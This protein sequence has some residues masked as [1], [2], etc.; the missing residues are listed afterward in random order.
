MPV[1]MN[2]LE[3]RSLTSLTQSRRVGRAQP[4]TWRRRSSLHLE[5]RKWQRFAVWEYP[6]SAVSN[7]FVTH[8]DTRGVGRAAC[9]LV[10]TCKSRSS[11]RCS[12]ML[13]LGR[14]CDAG[15]I[16]SSKVCP[17]VDNSVFELTRFAYFWLATSQVSNLVHSTPII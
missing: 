6:T 16:R 3:I 4:N 7:T 11:D 2:A 14:C 13:S 1:L 15:D 17:L 9:S 5:D 10:K 8:F 12:D